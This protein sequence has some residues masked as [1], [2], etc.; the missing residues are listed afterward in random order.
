MEI[1]SLYINIENINKLI[2]PTTLNNYRPI[3]YIVVNHL[4]VK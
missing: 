4:S 2:T 3:G 1:F